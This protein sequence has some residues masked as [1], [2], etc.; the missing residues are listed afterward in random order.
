MRNLVFAALLLVISMAC[1]YKK[2]DINVD[3]GK[4]VYKMAGGIGAS[5]HAIS[6]DTIDEAPEYKWAARYKNN[7]GSAWGGNPPVSNIEA[8]EQIYRHDSWLGMSFVRVDLSAGIYEP[9]RNRFDWENVEM[10]AL[11][12]IL[13]WAEANNADVFLQ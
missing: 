2:A 10:Q 7:R 4:I 8:W 6:E 13:D 1:N 11:Y 9:E 5:W 3:A 12:K